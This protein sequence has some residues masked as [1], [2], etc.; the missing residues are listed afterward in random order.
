M[1]I[2]RRGRSAPIIGSPS[3]PRP[4]VHLIALIVALCAAGA[5]LSLH[6]DTVPGLHGD[7][8][9]VGIRAHDILLGAR[10]VLG[11][12]EYTGAVHQYLVAGLMWV[13]GCHVW[14]LRAISV[15]CALAS[16]WLLSGVVRRLFDDLTATL[17]VAILIALPFYSA[18][19]RLAG[20]NFAL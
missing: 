16:V 15:V 14:V 18:F 2:R 4:R 19:G 6:L 11:M 13:F 12:N 3:G 10:P 5:V 8:A 20:E 7:E 9:W 1:G 17:S